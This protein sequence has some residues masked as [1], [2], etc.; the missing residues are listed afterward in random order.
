MNPIQKSSRLPWGRII[1]LI[2]TG[3]W[4]TAQATQFSTFQ[5][6]TG[7]SGDNVSVKDDAYPGT[8]SFIN[9]RNESACVN[10]QIVDGKRQVL[11]YSH[12]RFHIPPKRS[13][14]ALTGPGDN[15]KSI[16]MTIQVGAS[17]PCGRF[18]WLGTALFIDPGAAKD[19][20]NIKFDARNWNNKTRNIVI[21]IK[22]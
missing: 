6:Y 8:I 9:H 4:S 7:T 17:A 16:E 14:L 15:A 3:M 2:L 10:F 5:L 22:P 19:L 1:L 13:D 11:R 18:S 21:E 20:G 12:L